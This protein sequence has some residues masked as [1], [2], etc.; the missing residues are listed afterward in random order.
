MA[1]RVCGIFI[2]LAPEAAYTTG[3][4]AKSGKWPSCPGR[5]VKKKA[6][7]AGRQVE[8]P[9]SATLRNFIEPISRSALELEEVEVDGVY[10][11]D[12]DVPDLLR[13]RIHAYDFPEPW[14]GAKFQ[15]AADDHPV[16][17]LE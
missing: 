17:V 15:H 6:P 8:R 4:L 3:A 12:L 16:R 7:L 14:R 11:A 9:D 13:T 5:A 1:L 2:A 10:A